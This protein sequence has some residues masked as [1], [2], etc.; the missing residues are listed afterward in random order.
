MIS[1]TTNSSENLLSYISDKDHVIWD[2]NGTLLSDVQHAVDSMN[3]LLSEHALPFL[4][5]EKYRQIFEF[6]VRNYYETLGFNF[7]RESFESLCERFTAKFM[8]GF[9][10]LPLM[11]SM[12]VVLQ[13]IQSKSKIQSVLS[14][15]IQ[16]DLDEMI[17]HFELES[18]FKH[19]FGIDNKLGGSKIARGRE[20]V[21]L[22]KID[23]SKT[24]I[25]GDT[26]HDLEVAHDLG[27]DAILLAHGH[28]CAVRLRKHHNKV[29]E[30]N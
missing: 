8:S 9:K 10:H 11:P 24:V 22:S 17:R 7:E 14:A 4:E 25:I 15:T 1:K 20:L 2:W 12:K 30:L 21:A 29:I 23:P 5:V 13:D 6:P 27:I 19:V 26:L 28:Q 18:V 3:H 16:S